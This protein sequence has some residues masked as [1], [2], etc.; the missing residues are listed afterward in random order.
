MR[1]I[2]PDFATHLAGDATMTCHCWR[3]TRR[4]GV[5]LG[6]TEHD[7]DLFFAGTKFLAAS[8][9][10]ASDAEEAAGLPASTSSVAGGFSSDAI[11]ESD[12]NA[13]VYDGARVEVYLANWTAPEQHLLLK[14]QEI[15]EVTRQTGQFQA[16]LRSFAAR[17]SEPQGRIYTRRCDAVLGDSRCRVD[18]ANQRYRVE[19]MI[20]VVT[21]AT[22]LSLS[23][24]SGFTDG[25]FAHG[26]LV[27]LD[28]ANAGLPA[29]VDS[30]AMVGSLTQ[31][32]LWLPL[33]PTPDVGD[34]VALVTGC[35]KAFATC[36]SKFANSSNFRGFP[37]MPGSDFAYTYADGMTVHDGSPLF[38]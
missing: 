16:E 19:G 29:D 23:G 8:G 36:R 2:D 10:A 30:Q 11:T 24:I 5:V 32:T 4:D 17:L 13:G 18:V 35:D 31:I 27:F 25:F 37:H 14:V 9:F 22:R 38:P 34:R 1:K 3:L 12:L 21:D 28:G 7:R 33:A 15:G 26:K 20:A 6:F